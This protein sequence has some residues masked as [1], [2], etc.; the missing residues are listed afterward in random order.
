M[1]DPIKDSAES[2]LLRGEVLQI[3]NGLVS[4]YGE[5]SALPL[6]QLIS[7]LADVRN[8]IGWSNIREIRQLDSLLESLINLS[9]ANT[10]KLL[11]DIQEQDFMTQIQDVSAS[12]PQVIPAEFKNNTESEFKRA[13]DFEESA[14]QEV[15]LWAAWR[16]TETYDQEDFT[17]GDVSETLEEFAPGRSINVSRTL[18]LLAEKRNGFIEESGTYGKG[19]V[20][21][22]K[23][24]KVTKAGQIKSREVD[25]VR[26]VQ[27]S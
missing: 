5:S 14:D 6:V 8:Q 20:R 27:V 26:S 4:R 7:G 3:L 2:Q 25:Q 12:N 15:V 22:R 13:Y 1:N 10:S 9:E 24:F 11:E 16:F 21:K 17:T 19:T 23:I 18:Q